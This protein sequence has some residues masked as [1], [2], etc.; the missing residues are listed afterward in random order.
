MALISAADLAR[1][2]RFMP[3]SP[4]TQGSQRPTLALGRPAFACSRR[5]GHQAPS[6]GIFLA[7]DTTGLGLFI[8]ESSADRG[9]AYIID[10]KNNALESII[11]THNHQAV[12]H[13]HR[14]RWLD[15]FATKLNPPAF[16]RG[17]RERARAK[18]AGGPAPL[19]E[20]HACRH[21]G[22]LHEPRRAASAGT[23]IAMQTMQ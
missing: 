12:T 2:F 17:S 6:L 5:L 13:S 7:P 22:L 11:T 23:L 21:A 18:Q 15:G 16:D 19:V 14:T 9:T 3:A 20:S 10:G 1:K 8:Q 4:V